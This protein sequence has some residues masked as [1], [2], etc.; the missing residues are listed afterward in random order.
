[1]GSGLVPARGARLVNAAHFLRTESRPSLADRDG[2]DDGDA[3]DHHADRENCH[4]DRWGHDSRSVVRT[5]KEHM[6]RP[7]SADVARSSCGPAY[8]EDHSPLGPCPLDGTAARA[9]A[10]AL[11]DAAAYGRGTRSDSGRDRPRAVRDD[12]PL[13]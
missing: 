7:L 1:M 5:T 10:G 12:P 4:Q 3:G 8:G 9:T 11:A 13:P 2:P 6:P